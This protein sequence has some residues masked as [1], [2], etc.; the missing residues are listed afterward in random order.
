MQTLFSDN[1]LLFN[2]HKVLVIP[3]MSDA[4]ECFEEH[5]YTLYRFIGVYITQMKIIADFS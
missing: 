3:A 4:E 2:C 5:V 1:R